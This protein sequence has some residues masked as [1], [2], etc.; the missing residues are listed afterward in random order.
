MCILPSW[1]E[2]PGFHSQLCNHCGFSISLALP[3]AGYLGPCLGLK[4]ADHPGG[5]GGLFVLG[6]FDCF[7]HT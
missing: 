7:L 4:G 6:D 3:F 1:A 2:L 5:F